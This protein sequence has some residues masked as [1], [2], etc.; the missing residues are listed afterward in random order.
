[1]QSPLDYLLFAAGAAAFGSGLWLFRFR[2]IGIGRLR[3]MGGATMLYAAP[4]WLKLVS[5]SFPF[6]LGIGIPAGLALGIP[7]LTA[8]ITL[9]ALPRESPLH[10]AGSPLRASIHWVCCS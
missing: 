1:M 7:M 9:A 6:S 10:R 5:L 8:A 3:I 2:A 4:A